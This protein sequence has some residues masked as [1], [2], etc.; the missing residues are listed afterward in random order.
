M[1]EY[2]TIL[3]VCGDLTFGIPGSGYH[4][5]ALRNIFIYL[6]EEAQVRL[7]GEAKKALVPGGL[8][9]LGRVESLSRRS[10]HE[11]R[12]VVRDARIYARGRAE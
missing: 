2:F 9:I 12:T 4:V 1:S 7:L 5:I 10:S 3:P 6:T 11:W 8:L